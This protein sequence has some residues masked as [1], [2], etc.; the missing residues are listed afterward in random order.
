MDTTI[1]KSSYYLVLCFILSPLLAF[2]G[3]LI[4]IYNR[5]KYAIYL[6]VLFLSLCSY[7]YIPSGDLYR[8]W[9]L[10]TKYEDCSFVEMITDYHFDFFV[11]ILLW[12]AAKLDLGHAVVRF[13]LIFL[14]SFLYFHVI[15]N[16]LSKVDKRV[17]FF[18]LFLLSFLIFPY[19]GILTGLRFATALVFSFIS[20]YYYYYAKRKKVGVLFLLLAGL[21]HYAFIIIIPLLFIAQCK[22]VISRFFMILIC[23]IILLFNVVIISNIS[24]F[25]D[26]LIFNKVEAYTSGEDYIDTLSP[27]LR[28]V[29]FLPRFLSIP[30]LFYTLFLAPKSSFRN[31]LFCIGILVCIF[32]P[33][34][35]PFSRYLAV[36]SVLSFLG[37][38]LDFQ[39]KKNSYWRLLFF[40]SFCSF[41]LQLM[42]LYKPLFLSNYP[43]L[44]YTPYPIA[45]LK[46]YDAEWINEHV[47]LTG[48]IVK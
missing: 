30:M 44:L 31:Y 10:Y 43:S 22:I 5:R 42:P 46:T 39:R 16:L 15:W 3:I 2:G 41:I 8:Y 12:G 27:L 47:S 26:F 11:Y 34:E 19:L 29:M 1:R 40:C 35:T 25:S 18:F 14:S 24:F 48:E 32:L 38:L 13:V 45:L 7:I 20:A 33:F 17:H 36:F 23:S 21:T 37:Y 9:L 6:F 4:E 28:F